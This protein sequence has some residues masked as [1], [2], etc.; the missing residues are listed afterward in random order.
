MAKCEITGKHTISGSNIPESYHRT[1][2]TFKPNIQKKTFIIDGKKVTFKNISAAGIRT[3][4]KKG[5]IDSPVKAAPA[6]KVAS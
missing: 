6:K 1:K 4:K 3:L 5:L 2:R